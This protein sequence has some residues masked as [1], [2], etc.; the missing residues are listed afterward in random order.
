MSAANPEAAAVAGLKERLFH[1]V[2]G[3]LSTHPAPDGGADRR[4]WGRAVIAGALRDLAEEELRA[5]R[6]PPARSAEEQAARYVWDALF[7][8]GGLQPLLDDPEVENINC[9]GCDVVHVRRADGSRQQVRPVAATDAELVDLI[10]TVAARGTSGERRLDRGS[11]A[12][13]VELPD[14]S[15]LFA[16]LDISRRPAIAIRRHRYRDVT[17]AELERLGTIDPRVRALLA[18]AVKAPLNIVVSGGTAAGKTTLL[19]ALCAEIPPAER[20]VTIEDAYELGLG[21]EHRIHPDVVELQ[22]RDP[23]TEGA[24]AVPLAKLTR[25]AL[26]MSP[27]R[28]IVGEVRGSEGL[29]MVQAMSQGNDGSMSTVHASTSAGAL[30]RLATYLMRAEGVSLTTANLMLSGAIH[31]VAH[32]DTRADGARVVTSIREVVGADGDHVISNEIIRPAP[33]ASHTGRGGVPGA[34]IRATTMDKLASAG[35]TPELMAD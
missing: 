3:R 30:L 9:N 21:R 24:G 31:L 15:R 28:V 25:W 4:E 22:A 35:F 19:R 33:D 20:L 29:P 6:T 14:G 11:P 34:P 16:V 1:D 8:L 10:R 17:L 32:L 5:G 12:V 13:S 23:N 7:G 26:R 2:R 18:A 27:D